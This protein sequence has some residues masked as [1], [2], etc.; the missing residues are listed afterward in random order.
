MQRVR[1]I[2]CAVL[3]RRKKTLSVRLCRDGSN[4]DVRFRRCRVLDV[5]VGGITAGTR[6]DVIKETVYEGEEI[7]AFVQTSMWKS[8]RR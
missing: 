3:H 7:E 2:G 5:R 8:E 4:C 6:I 1:T